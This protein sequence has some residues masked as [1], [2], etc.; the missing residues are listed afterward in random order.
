MNWLSAGT[1]NK[2]VTICAKWDSV[3]SWM[4]KTA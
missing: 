1:I 2:A 4:E 3:T